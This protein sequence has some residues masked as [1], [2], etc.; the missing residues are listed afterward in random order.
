MGRVAENGSYLVVGQQLVCSGRF[1]ERGFVLGNC[2]AHPRR[3]RQLLAHA[4]GQPVLGS[5]HRSPLRLQVE[6]S[7]PPAQ[8]CPICNLA[9]PS[10]PNNPLSCTSVAGSGSVYLL[11]VGDHGIPGPSGIDHNVGDLFNLAAQTQMNSLNAAG[12]GVISC[13]VSTVE[14]VE[15]ALT[16][17][18]SI[19]GGVYYFGH[20]GFSPVANSM[21]LFVGQQQGTDTNISSLNVGQLSGTNLGPHAAITISACNAGLPYMGQPA[22]AQLLSNQLKRGVYA[23]EVGMFFSQNPNDQH[24]NGIGVPNPPDTTPIYMIPEGAV[25]KPKPVGFV[26]Q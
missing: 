3:S 5:R 7:S 23:Y 24:I 4:S 21:A 18:G 11:L 26:P 19:D 12:S 9:P 8:N 20:A 13:H 25:P 22:I 14:D 16:L 6:T 15:N 17:N 2:A 10:P 1:G